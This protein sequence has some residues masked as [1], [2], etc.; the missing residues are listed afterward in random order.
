VVVCVLYVESES[1]R[2]SKVC[3]RQDIIILGFSRLPDVTASD[4]ELRITCNPT[5][6]SDS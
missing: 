2:A 5:R 6:L 3:F 4:Y 1:S